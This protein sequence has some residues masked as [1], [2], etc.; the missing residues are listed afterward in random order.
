MEIRIHY[1]DL[2]EAIEAHLAKKH[3]IEISLPQ[4]IAECYL[5]TDHGDKPDE[6]TRIMDGETI[7]IYL[8]D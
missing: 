3:K 1:S 2:L 6:F 8:K 7:S 4:T 5:V